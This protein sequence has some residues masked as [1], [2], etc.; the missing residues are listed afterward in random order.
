MH[1]E[2]DRES[3]DGGKMCRK[4][5]CRRCCFGF[6]LLTIWIFI[7]MLY[8]LVNRRKKTFVAQFKSQQQVNLVN[9]Q[10]V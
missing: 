8:F 9:Y 3:Y 5:A 10:N 1:A 7:F 4:N 2:D 6:V